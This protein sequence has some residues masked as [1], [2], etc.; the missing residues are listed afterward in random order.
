VEKKQ[1]TVTPDWLANELYVFFQRSLAPGRLAQVA[2][3]LG[4]EEHGR[5]RF[6]ELLHVLMVLKLWLVVRACECAE[7]M[8]DVDKRD[9]CLDLF[10]SLVYES[11]YE[12]VGLSYA[13][14][15]ETLLPQYERLHSAYDQDPAMGLG[16]V[17]G[18]WL[19][20]RRITDIRF[21]GHLMAHVSASLEALQDMLGQCRLQD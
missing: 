6:P 2:A 9:Q 12:D 1:Q 15:M 19:F 20:G 10:H 21:Y 16:W 14:W 11:Y 13:E 7:T 3:D 18:E 4:I 8:D 5:V 17:V